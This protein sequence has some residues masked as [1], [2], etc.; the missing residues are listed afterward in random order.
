MRHCCEVNKIGLEDC[1][2]GLSIDDTV[3]RLLFILL[4]YKFKPWADF[5]KHLFIIT[6]TPGGYLGPFQVPNPE[7]VSKEAGPG[8]PW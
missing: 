3:N 5:R 2:Y 4:R 1:L 7:C 6:P 8:G